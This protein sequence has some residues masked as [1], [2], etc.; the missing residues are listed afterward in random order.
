MQTDFSNETTPPTPDLRARFGHLV[1]RIYRQWRRQI[2]LNFKELG[3]SDATRKPLLELYVQGKPLLQKELADALYLDTSSLVRVL[4]QLREANLL[5]WS[6]DPADR[7]S[8]RISLTPAGHEAAAR[9]LTK[10]LEIEHTIL[11]DLSHEELD[12]TRRTLEKISRR[13]DALQNREAS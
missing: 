3:L 7:R 10:S 5:D 6:S 8:K 13:F 9:I 11:A 2:D 4:A 12:I 1:G